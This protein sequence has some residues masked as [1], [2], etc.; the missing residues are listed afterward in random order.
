MKI[1]YFTEFMLIIGGKYWK[2]L[3]VELFAKGALFKIRME[4]IV[5]VSVKRKG[6]N[7]PETRQNYW[8]K[9]IWDWKISK[10]I[11]TIVIKKFKYGW[12]DLLGGI[13][14]KIWW[15]NASKKLLFMHFAWQKPKW[16]G[17]FKYYI[18][19]LRGR[20]SESALQ[21]HTKVCYD[22]GRGVKKTGKLRYVILELLNE[23][24]S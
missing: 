19:K 14:N 16:R 7:W 6:K 4:R 13:F 20:G 3:A 10:K 8:T 24:D 12:R 17:A 22:G 9:L 21:K 2:N 5:K 18:T 11:K 15:R 1:S 23:G